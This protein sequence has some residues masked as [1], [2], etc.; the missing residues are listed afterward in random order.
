MHTMN[1]QIN[2]ITEIQQS[3]EMWRPGRETTA[4]ELFQINRNR[5]LYTVRVYIQWERN[6]Y[7]IV[8]T[9]NNAQSRELTIFAVGG[10]NKHQQ[11]KYTHSSSAWC[12]DKGNDSEKFNMQYLEESICLSFQ[13]YILYILTTLHTP[14]LIKQQGTKQLCS[15]QNK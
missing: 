1:L 4:H 10:Y 13:P 2:R 9:R 8:Y 15:D 12:G 11:N 14:H 3:A 6:I 5:I 7:Q